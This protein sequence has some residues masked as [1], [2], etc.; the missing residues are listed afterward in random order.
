MWKEQIQDEVWTYDNFFTESQINHLL[1]FVT[2]DNKSV[3][4]PNDGIKESFRKSQ[5]NPTLYKYQVH[6]SD[7][8]TSDIKDYVV[9]K[10]NDLAIPLM[11]KPARNTDLNSLNLFLKSF[12]TGSK[13]DLHVEPM[14]KYGPFFMQI[15]LT[16]ESQGALVLP[17]KQQANQYIS[18]H[19]DQKDAWEENCELVESQ[20]YP[21]RYVGTRIEPKKNSA[22][23]MRVGSAHYVE[24][25]KVE[26]DLGRVCVSGWPYAGDELVSDLNKYCRTDKYFKVKT[27]TGI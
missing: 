2:N 26:T 5:V 24:D 3:L 16:D 7:I 19:T 23:V 10:F 13:Y 15:F 8:R 6:K 9:D 4:E 27:D 25:Y 14:E 21:V 17:T 12:R 22:M 20:G 11:S 18:E 1:S